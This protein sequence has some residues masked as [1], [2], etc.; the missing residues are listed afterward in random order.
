MSIPTARVGQAAAA[1][2]IVVSL[3]TYARSAQVQR[4]AVRSQP[5]PAADSRA[6]GSSQDDAAL[7]EPHKPVDNPA[8][9]ARQAFAAYAELARG[10]AVAQRAGASD[11]VPALKAKCDE[12]RRVALSTTERA[13]AIANES[14]DTTPSE[15]VELLQYQL[16]YLHWELE[17]YLHSAVLGGR[18]AAS[19]GD[20]PQVRQGAAIA[21]ASYQRIREQL[22]APDTAGGAPDTS[23]A[24]GDAQKRRSAEAAVW[25]EKIRRLAEVIAAK[26]PDSEHADDAVAILAG[27]ALERGDLATAQRRLE[28]GKPNTPRRANAEVRLGI[29]LAQ[30]YLA[31]QGDASGPSTNRASSVPGAAP[32]DRALARQAE[33]SITRGLTVLTKLKQFDANAALGAYILCRLMVSDNRPNEALPWLDDAKTGLVTLA[34]ERHPAVAADSFSQDIFKLALATYI[35]ADQLERIPS[36]IAAFELRFGDQPSGKLRAQELCVALGLELLRRREA[37][38]AEGKRIE[39]A[40]VESVLVEILNRTDPQ[41]AAQDWN[42]LWWTGDTFCKLGES[43]QDA[44]PSARKKAHQHFAKAAQIMAAAIERGQKE[45]GFVPTPENLTAA[46]IRLARALQGTGRHEQAIKTL[47]EVL[48]K[49]P[50]LVDAQFSAAQAF[51]DYAAS[52]PDRAGYYRFAIGGGEKAEFRAIWG[53]GRLSK[54]LLADGAQRGR[55]FEARYNLALCRAKWG[56]S[57]SDPA[58]R[59]ALLNAARQEIWSVYSVV[60][61]GLGGE[62]WR[63]RYEELLKSI[64]RSLN[65]PPEGLAEFARRL[66]PAPRSATAAK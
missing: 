17:N 18:L 38:S 39:A 6:K 13:F 65:Q 44:S 10:L 61:Q 53:W 12:L 20:H 64:Q 3:W 14:L 52:H 47:A 30:K 42:T 50:N 9:Q 16:C 8:E 1:A 26:W 56:Q 37:L 51:Q 35:A 57:E 58:R 33:V 43:L 63:A 59:Q 27:L 11:Q 25:S 48:E 32:P 49:R 46:K 66:D 19:T 31:S 60:D 22:L 40:A 2:A 23:E 21:L 62:P 45:P 15:T 4:G 54:A 5:P 55:F 41:Q 28:Q 34:K 7:A 36:T 29:A 24:S